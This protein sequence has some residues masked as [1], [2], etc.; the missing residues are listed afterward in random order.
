MEEVYGKKEGKEQL[1]NFIRSQGI[2]TPIGIATVSN[3][4][5]MQLEDSDKKELRMLRE[6][7]R[8]QG[9]SICI[10]FTKL[11]YSF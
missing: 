9:I 11:F 2:Y 8:G 1:S 7:F 3:I 5:H 6:I 10:R 4:G